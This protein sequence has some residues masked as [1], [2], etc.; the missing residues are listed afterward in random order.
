MACCDVAVCGP[1]RGRRRHDRQLLP[2]AAPLV[3]DNTGTH[4][5]S[6]VQAWFAR[7]PRYDVDFTQTRGVERLFAVLT[8]RCVRRGSHLAVRSLE[9]AMMDRPDHRNKNSKPFAWTADGVLVP[10]RSSASVNVFLIQDTRSRQNLVPRPRPIQQVR[11]R[12]FRPP[13]PGSAR[14]SGARAGFLAMRVRP[15]AAQQDCVTPCRNWG[16]STALSRAFW[17]GARMCSMA[18]SCHNFAASGSIFPWFRYPLSPRRSEETLARRPKSWP[19][20]SRAAPV[21]NTLS[22]TAYLSRFRKQAVIVQVARDPIGDEV[23]RQFEKGVRS[24][25]RPELAGIVA[26]ALLS[27]FREYIRNGE[28]LARERSFLEVLSHH[29]GETLAEYPALIPEL[30]AATILC[31]P[32]DRGA[33]G[34]RTDRTGRFQGS[35]ADRIGD[36]RTAVL[37]FHGGCRSGLGRDDCRSE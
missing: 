21:W 11:V 37:A 17:A 32:G 30:C 18:S 23:F 12:C 36:S 5:V 20:G 29:L 13:R 10:A 35:G 25:G 33:S 31:W 15:M 6:Q 14:I 22:R 2:S 3:M 26:P 34:F 7:H 1:R 24:L 8:E 4:K 19:R 27:Q 16:E 9:R 28:S